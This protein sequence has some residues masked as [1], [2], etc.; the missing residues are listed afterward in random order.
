LSSKNLYQARD[1]E[2]F[3][4]A[5]ERMHSDPRTQAAHAV[6]TGSAIALI[7]VGAWRRDPRWF[8]L[9][10]IVDYAIAQSSHRL[11][12]HNRTTPL[13]RPSWHL[14]AELRLF[15]RTC[16]RGARHLARTVAR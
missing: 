4:R 16:A 2:T 7:A 10:P 12:Q 14:R 1:F 6:A 15:R 8:L 5:Y 13:R 3:W 9:A 11:I